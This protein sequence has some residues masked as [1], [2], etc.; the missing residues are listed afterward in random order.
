[1]GLGEAEELLAHPGQ[2]TALVIMKQLS[3]EMAGKS[4]QFCSL[5][6]VVPGVEGNWASGNV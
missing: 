2:T 5:Y 6:Q 3:V 4:R 1:M